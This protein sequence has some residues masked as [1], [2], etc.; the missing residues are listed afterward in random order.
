MVS[1]E[2]RTPLTSIRGSLGLL[3]GGQLGELPP[4]AASLVGVAVQN[5]ERLTRLINDLLDIERMDSGVAPME[6]VTLDVHELL[7]AATEQIDG[8]ATSVGVRVE[9]GSTRGPRP[10]RRG[11]GHPDP[12][13]PAR[14]RDQ[15]LRARIR[16]PRRRRA[17]GAGGPLPGERRRPRHPGRQAGEHLRPVRAGR[18]LRHPAAGRDRP[19]PDHQ[20]GHRGAAGWPDLGGERARPR[21]DGP[22]H[23][24]RSVA[25]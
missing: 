17:G 5:S 20:Q 15:V 25:T 10:R 13:E 9:L 12:H 3:A 8:M 16:R 1:H 4:R 19:G 7:E 18:L 23:P 2:L 21:H 11:P 22:L 14:Q 24:A 6:L